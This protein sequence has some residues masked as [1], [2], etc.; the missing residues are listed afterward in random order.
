[1]LYYVPSHFFTYIFSRLKRYF[2]TLPEMSKVDFD[3]STEIVLEKHC[4]AAEFSIE[5]DAKF[6]AALLAFLASSH[7]VF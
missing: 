4:N 1:M 2:I 6:D 5:I 3:Y 7:C